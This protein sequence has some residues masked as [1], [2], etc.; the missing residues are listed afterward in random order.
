MRVRRCSNDEDPGSSIALQDTRPHISMTN[1]CPPKRKEEDRALKAN[2]QEPQRTRGNGQPI[3]LEAKQEPRRVSCQ[4]SKTH[5][6]QDVIFVYSEILISGIKLKWFIN[7]KNKYIQALCPLLF[8][9]E[10][11][12]TWS[13]KN[14]DFRKYV[15]YRNHLESQRNFSS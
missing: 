15:K 11:H 7:N 13:L 12:S 2:G 8:S 14:Q 4:M 5:Q 3:L 9:D 6:I 10:Y 1:L